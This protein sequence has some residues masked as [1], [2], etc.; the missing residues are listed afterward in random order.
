MDLFALI[1]N[2]FPKLAI[3]KNF[4]F[5]RHTTIGCGGYAAL[6]TS[7]QSREEAAALLSYLE[8][9]CIPHCFLGAGA[10]VLPSDG[11]YEGVVVRFGKLKELWEKDGLIYADAGITGGALC[12]FSWEHGIGGF[13]PFTGIPMTVGGGIVMNAGIPPRHFS[14]VVELVLGIEKGKF[15]VYRN[16]DCNFS[17]KSSIFQSGI[18]VVGA[19]LRGKLSSREEIARYTEEYRARRAN[20]PKGRSMGCVFVNP[21]GDSAGRLIES[22][23]LKGWRIGGAKV[24]EIHANFILNEGG[25]SRD[26]AA[27]IESIKNIV[28]LRFGILLREEIRRIP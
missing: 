23:G 21:P 26:I 4:S 19:Y 1:G 7:P 3:E 22:C 17:E 11:F 15:R 27:L 20:L 6:A 2:H 16:Q 24:S 9:E 13:E 14:D 18:V 8:K 5:T 25:S 12:R 10:N 28:Q